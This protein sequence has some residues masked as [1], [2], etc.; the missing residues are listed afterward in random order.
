[1]ETG[2][3][4]RAVIRKQDKVAKIDSADGPTLARFWYTRHSEEKVPRTLVVSRTVCITL[5]YA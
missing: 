1:M 2:E 3:V 4:G 5:L